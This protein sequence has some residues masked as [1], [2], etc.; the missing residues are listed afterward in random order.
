MFDRRIAVEDCF[1]VKRYCKI[2]VDRY[3]EALD[4]IICM[5]WEHIQKEK[6]YGIE[7]RSVYKKEMTQL[8]N[9]VNLMAFGVEMLK[10][11]DPFIVLKEIIKTDAEHA[12]KLDK[13]CRAEEACDLLERLEHLELT[14]SLMKKMLKTRK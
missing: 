7:W 11:S 1:D 13:A 10:G 6:E 5:K 12:I 3:L 14:V 2:I 4:N 8:A 9:E